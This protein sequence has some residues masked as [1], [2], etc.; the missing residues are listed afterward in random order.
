MPKIVAKIKAGGQ[1]IR[2]DRQLKPPTAAEFAKMQ[3]CLAEGRHHSSAAAP[4]GGGSQG[5]QGRAA[6]DSA[7]GGQAAAAATGARS[8]KCLPARL[9]RF[10]ATITTP[11]QTLQQVVNP[12]QTNIKSSAYTIAGVDPTTPGIGV[13]TPSLVSRGRF[14]A[15]SCRFARGSL[16][17]ASYASRQGLK[18]GSKLDLN[19]TDVHRGRPRAPAARRPDRRRVCRAAAAAGAREP[20]GRGERRCSCA[21]PAAPRSVR[22]RQQIETQF[23]ARPG[24]ER[25]AGGRLD[26]RLPRRRLQPLASA[27]GPRSPCS[28]RSPPSSSPSS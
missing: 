7:A 16:W 19:G 23:P 21:R 17:R 28:R 26:Q 13:V 20:E 6:A 5:G 3:T 22:C 11:E 1:Q 4:G 24:R 8:R 14:I 18:V 27:S 12:P 10:R 2:V 9:Q 25:E 15:A